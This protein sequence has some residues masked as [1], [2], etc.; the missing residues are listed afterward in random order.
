MIEGVARNL[1]DYEGYAREAG[2]GCV[3][4][5]FHRQWELCNAAAFPFQL[6]VIQFTSGFGSEIEAIL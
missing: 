2:I 5:W 1:F 6:C 3:K 4:L